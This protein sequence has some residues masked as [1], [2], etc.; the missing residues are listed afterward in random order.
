MWKLNGILYVSDYFH[1][2][3]IGSTCDT[4]TV[5]AIDFVKAE[6]EVHHGDVCGVE[7]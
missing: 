7:V 6:T 3:R 1:G 4:V 5:P 2:E